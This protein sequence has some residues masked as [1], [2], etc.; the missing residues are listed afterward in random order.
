MR[1][2]II[3]CAVIVLGLLLATIQVP[4]LDKD[5]INKAIDDAIS[6]IK[7]TP[8][9]KNTVEKAVLL[10]VRELEKGQRRRLMFLVSAYLIIWLVFMLYLL[11]MGKQQLSLDQRILQLEQDAPIQSEDSS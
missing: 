11:R 4:I 1:I 8:E 7:V 2:T 9:E 3:V 6:E 5:T 10:T